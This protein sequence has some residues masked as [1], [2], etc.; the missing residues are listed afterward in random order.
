MKRNSWLG[1]AIVPRKEEFESQYLAAQ[2]Q[3]FEDL[4][5]SLHV[6][7]QSVVHIHHAHNPERV[8]KHLERIRNKRRMRIQLARA[9]A[10]NGESVNNIS[11]GN[12][13]G[14]DLPLKKKRMVRRVNKWILTTNPPFGAI[15]INRPKNV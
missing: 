6:G 5:E 3:G 15:Q 8:R 4:C 2:L 1:N 12:V 14:T 7:S 13:E 10:E 9:M 11:S